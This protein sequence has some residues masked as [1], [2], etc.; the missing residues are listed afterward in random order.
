MANSGFSICALF[1]YDFVL[2]PLRI[3]FNPRLSRFQ[4]GSHQIYIIQRG[5]ISLAFGERSRVVNVAAAGLPFRQRHSSSFM[6]CVDSSCKFI[7]SRELPRAH[8]RFVAAICP[9]LF[10]SR[11]VKSALFTDDRRDFPTTVARP[12]IRP[13]DIHAGRSM[14]VPCRSV[15]RL[16]GGHHGRSE[17][18]Q[19]A[20]FGRETKDVVVVSPSLVCVA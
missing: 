5:V 6:I 3:S 16:M 11:T 20:S 19:A 7:N 2:Q 4:C 17:L 12:R 18:P 14:C 9:N 13:I 15:L 8:C 10:H 1:L